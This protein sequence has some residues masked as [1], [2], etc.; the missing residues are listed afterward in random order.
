MPVQNH[1]RFGNKDR[2]IKTW[3]DPI[4]GNGMNIYFGE[5]NLELLPH[6]RGVYIYSGCYVYIGYWHNGQR[7]AAPGNFIKIESDGNF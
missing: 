6:G 2:E 4:S 7:E 3:I 1:L 5:V